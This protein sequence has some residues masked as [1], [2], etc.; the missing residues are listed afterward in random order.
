[1]SM[2]FINYHVLYRISLSLSQRMRQSGAFISTSESVLF[3]L[4]HDS[5]HPKFREVQGL[6]KT[7]APDSGLLTKL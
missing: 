2:A 4:L 6:I 7:S 5:K 3:E 1:M